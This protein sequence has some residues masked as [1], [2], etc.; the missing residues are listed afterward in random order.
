MKDRKKMETKNVPVVPASQKEQNLVI[1][2]PGLSAFQLVNRILSIN[3]ESQH[4]ES[5]VSFYPDFKDRETLRTHT[6]W[7]ALLCL[8]LSG[9]TYSRRN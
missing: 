2:C 7:S 6:A 9:P 4:C 3:Q 1:T 5:G 8:L